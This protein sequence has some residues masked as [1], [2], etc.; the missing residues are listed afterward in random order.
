MNQNNRRNFLMKSIAAGT[1]HCAG[2]LGIKASANNLR[3]INESVFTGMS[4][5]EVLRFALG[6]SLPVL[7]K[8]QAE[9]GE[10]KFTGVLK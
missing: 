9:I 1:A 8:M 10:K 7:K 4:N 2:C 5:E 3:E 6:Y